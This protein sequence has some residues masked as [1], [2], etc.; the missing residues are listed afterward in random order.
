MGKI[1]E[2]H[3]I[4]DYEILT[5]SG[6]KDLQ[7]VHI[8]IPYKVW[9][10]QTNNFTLKCADTHILFD[11]N[12]N[13]LYAKDCLGKYI[14]TQ[15]GLEMVH[16]LQE[17]TEETPMYDVSVEGERYF[18]S[19]IASHNTTTYT[20]FA[21]YYLL[22][23]E[24]KSVLIAANKEKVAREFL[25]RIKMAYTM[26]PDFLK[27]GI[28]TWAGN[29]VKFENKSVLRC[30]A[31]SSDAAR[32]STCDVCFTKDTWIP[33]CING[34][35]KQIP[36]LELLEIV[37][38]T[39][40]IINNV[41]T[42]PPFRKFPLT[43]FKS[44]SQNNYHT[45]YSVDSAPKCM[46]C[47]KPLDSH[48]K[49]NEYP[50]VCGLK[51]WKKLNLEIPE[52]GI[53]VLTKTGFSDF[54][55]I[56]ITTAPKTYEVRTKNFSG[57]FTETHSLETN[58]GFTY[59][60]ELT[61]KMDL[62]TFLG[63][64]SIESILINSE[65][66]IVYD[67]INVD[68]GHTFWTNGLYSHNCILDEAAFI[69]NNIMDQFVASVFPTISSRPEGKIIAVSTPNG[70][71]NWFAETWHKAILDV[72][73]NETDHNLNG[74]EIWH[75]I[76]FDWWE[77]PD[78][79]D[80]F[81]KKM[82]VMLGS[83]KRWNQEFGLEFLGSSSTLIDGKILRKLSDEAVL[84]KVSPIRYEEVLGRKVA[85]YAEP[86]E[87]HCY[88]L[89]VDP[90]DGSQ[91]DNSVFIILD[92]SDVKNLEVVAT[93]ASDSITPLEFAYLTVK[94]GVRYNTALICGERNGIG[95]GFF[96]TMFSNYEYENLIFYKSAQE[97]SDK[98]GIWLTNKTKLQG[99]LWLKTLIE[100]IGKPLKNSSNKDCS[101]NIHLN[102]NHIIHELQFFERKE[103]GTSITYQAS[104]NY[105][106][107]YVMALVWAV[108][109]ILKEVSD[110]CLNVRS[111]MRTEFNLEL[112]EY[113]QP[114]NIMMDESKIDKFFIDTP[115]KNQEP[116]LDSNFDNL[117]EQMWG[118]NS[119]EVDTEL[120]QF[121]R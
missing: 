14:Q 65:P 76:R 55:G 106:D 112:P 111:T 120:K 54:G 6:W 70:T 4:S 43:Q 94:F 58:L 40:T 3:N 118:Q 38:N 62:I 92:V 105:H 82:Q 51:C 99:C 78:R 22:F 72:Q 27:I 26:L 98:P 101:L 15:N 35:V 109:P 67:L 64:E 66:T 115:V 13:E 84:Q 121:L 25:Q 79:D 1:V 21:L 5:P 53:K 2:T 12:W 17:T 31:T 23:N 71:G 44:F 52:T 10:I 49:H 7:S 116:Q 113:I 57:T 89:G 63:K 88:T 29:E 18:S 48:F 119:Q 104:Q 60:G 36:I 46:V 91:H 68:S 86:K 42:L 90:S 8:T 59:V 102:D 117:Q 95:S 39:H 24:N 73:D 85:I 47:G 77:R 100:L 61:P 87:G 30:C 74:N 37:K 81:R 16:T 9:L 97:K 75:P 103:T 50:L 56:H 93:F 33:V 107:D 34:H 69:P 96:D 110:M 20:V 19:G 32:G 108:F 45:L 80:N 83:E 11:E 28:I 114:L 41:K